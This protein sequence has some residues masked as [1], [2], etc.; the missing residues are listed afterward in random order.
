MTG[1][2]AGKMTRARTWSRWRGQ[3]EQSEMSLFDKNFH[4]R[5][6]ELKLTCPIG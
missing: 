4:G 2:Q 6:N 1:G 3:A 5:F